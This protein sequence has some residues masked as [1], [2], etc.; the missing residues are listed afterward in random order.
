M[1]GTLDRLLRLRQHAV[2][3]ARREL[4]S[5]RAMEAERQVALNG[6]REQAERDATATLPLVAADPWFAILAAQGRQ[7]ARQHQEAA[8][9]LAD[10]AARWAETARDEL[11]AAKVAAEIVL[12]IAAERRASQSVR[13]RACENAL[14]L[15]AILH[16]TGAG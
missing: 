8:R 5:R 7:A 11:A 15:E 14:L 10:A 2:E 1:A 4:L 3:Q 6:L 9:Q 12:T 16:E 13:D